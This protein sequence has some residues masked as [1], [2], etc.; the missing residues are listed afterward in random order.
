ME[1]I[2]NVDIFWIYKNDLYFDNLTEH[3]QAKY[4]QVEGC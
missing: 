2:Q 3:Y 1:L 4:I